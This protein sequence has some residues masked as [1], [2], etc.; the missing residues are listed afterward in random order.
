MVKNGAV[1]EIRGKVFD[2]KRT[3]IMGI[4]NVTP[5]SFSD[6]GMFTDSEGA[7]ARAFEMSGQGADIID[8]G[9]ESTRPGADKVSAEEEIKRVIPVIEKIRKKNNEIIISVDTYKAET[10]G[11]AMDAGAD[12]INDISG[13][14]FDSRMFKT[15]AVKKAKYIIMH[16][17]GT[18]GNMQDNPVYPRGVVK[19]IRDFFEAQSLKAVEAGIRKDDIIID[20]GIGFGKTAEDNAVILENIG[21]FVS[22][23][24]PVMVGTSRKS[25][26]GKATGKDVSERKFGTA[27]AVALSIS[28]GARI[29]RVHDVVEMKDVVKVSDFIANSGGKEKVT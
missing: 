23:G 11:K 28:K 12:M 4:L 8:I 19:E 9:G 6:G 29:V 1:M 26:I 20:P 17:K 2:F 10:A 15:A 5:D 21:E 3:Y 16:I 24:F 13:G 14:V 27:A 18:P 22:L 25:M 7:A